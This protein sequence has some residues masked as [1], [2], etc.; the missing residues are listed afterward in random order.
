MV[1]EHYMTIV[2]ETIVFTNALRFF[3]FFFPA[4]V[5]LWS[6]KKISL[7]WQV[8]IKSLVGMMYLECCFVMI[9]SHVGMTWGG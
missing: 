5:P 7:T 1:T 6:T 3:F 4:V 9:S 2:R 8:R